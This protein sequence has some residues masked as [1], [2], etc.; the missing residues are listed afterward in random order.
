M[1]LF[2]AIELDDPVRAAAAALASALKRRADRL[3]PR[4]RLTWVAPERMHLTLRFIGEVSDAD[5]ERVIS[6]LR[7]PLPMPPFVAR[8]A[9]AGAYPKK[10]P[11]RV[12][13]VGMAHGH[14]AAVRAE[15]LVGERLRALGIPPEDRPY[16]P[17]LTLARVRDAA[18]LRTAPLIEGVAA[19]LGET[20]VDAITLF[21]SKLSPKGPSYVVLE[22]T[23]L[24]AGS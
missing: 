14:E 4:A 12:I 19:D 18:G 20:R 22:R 15:A 1:R 24:A 13:W 16:S 10:G 2:T 6:A 9:G 5:G 7:N 8:F 17:H 23:P 21:Q 3:A 11:P